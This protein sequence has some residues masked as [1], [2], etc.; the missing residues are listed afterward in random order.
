MVFP[1][2]TLV[3]LA[4]NQLGRHDVACPECGPGR[5]RKANQKREV[6]RVWLSETFASYH[7][8]RCGVSGYAQDDDHLASVGPAR[9]FKPAARTVS[10]EAYA[11]EQLRK[12]RFLWNC[13]APIGGTG[14]ETYLRSAR[15]I[16]CDLPPTLR[17]LAPRNPEHHPAMIAPFAMASEPEPGKLLVH[18]ADIFAVHLTLLS[19]D[20]RSKATAEREKI[21]RRP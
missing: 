10:N 4:G 17:Y 9:T 18:D 12:A 6:L 14:A 3:D 21:M 8:A 13:S 2:S 1:Y 15:G 20:G 5:R 16:A 11:A 7:C 19:A